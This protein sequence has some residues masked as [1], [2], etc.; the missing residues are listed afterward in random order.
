MDTKYDT[1]CLAAPADT[2]FAIRFDNEDSDTHNLD[3]MNGGISLFTGEI[4][5]GPKIVTY[6]VGP[7]AAGSYTFRCDV[8]P[9]QMHGTFVVNG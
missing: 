9:S 8:H 4:V 2:P 5:V 7:L 6:H 3:I 1:A